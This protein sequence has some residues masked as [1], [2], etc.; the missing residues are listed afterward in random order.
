MGPCIYG[1]DEM[2]GIPHVEVVIILAQFFSKNEVRLHFH[3]QM[4]CRAFE[5][6][7]AGLFQVERDGHAK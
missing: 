1:R 7:K 2:F 3:K 4:C 5:I 6:S